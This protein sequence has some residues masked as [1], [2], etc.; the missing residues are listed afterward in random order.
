MVARNRNI[1]YGGQKQKYC[2]WWPETEILFDPLHH[3]SPFIGGKC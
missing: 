2:L 3:S 1:V